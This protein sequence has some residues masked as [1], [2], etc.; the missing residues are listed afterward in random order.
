MDLIFHDQKASAN[1]LDIPEG[2]GWI[3]LQSQYSNMKGRGSSSQKHLLNDFDSRFLLLI[4]N[5][6]H[7]NS[8]VEILISMN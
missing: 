4:S 1:S 2:F 8:F 6:I 7:N 3:G 5:S